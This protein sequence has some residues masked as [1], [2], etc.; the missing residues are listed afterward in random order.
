MAIKPIYKF[1][2]P[3]FSNSKLLACEIGN[4]GSISAPTRK[5][6]AQEKCPIKEAE[7]PSHPV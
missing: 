2:V 3:F 1:M 4:A 5:G 6:D 7:I